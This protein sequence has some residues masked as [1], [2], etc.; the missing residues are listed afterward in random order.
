MVSL[1]RYTLSL[2]LLDVSD[3]AAEAPDGVVT[4]AMLAA[5]ERCARTD[6]HR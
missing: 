4:G 2:A 3:A 6:D 5:D 1:I